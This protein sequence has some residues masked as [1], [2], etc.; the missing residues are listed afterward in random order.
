MNNMT[1]RKQ[2]LG[3]RAEHYCKTVYQYEI[4]N[5]QQKCRSIFILV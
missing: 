5:L 2:N 3:T 1:Q 4:A